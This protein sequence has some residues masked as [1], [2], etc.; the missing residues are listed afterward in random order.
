[1]HFNNLGFEIAGNASLR[2]EVRKQ[3]MKGNEYQNDSKRSYGPEYKYSDSK[4]KGQLG[5]L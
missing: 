4:T 2:Q 3:T 5:Q 1:M